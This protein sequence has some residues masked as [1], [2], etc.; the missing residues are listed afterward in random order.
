MSKL[1]VD[2]G[3]LLHGHHIGHDGLHTLPHLSSSMRCT[4]EHCTESSHSLC[5][6]TQ[7]PPSREGEEDVLVFIAL[8]NERPDNSQILFEAGLSLLGQEKQGGSLHFQLVLE[9]LDPVTLLLNSPT[10]KLAT[11]STRPLGTCH[12]Q[13]VGSVRSA[14][15][16]LEELSCGRLGP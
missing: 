12:H 11:C 2:D 5:M 7:L 1:P 6:S 3:L 15:M 9:Y 14:C 10:L 4:S 16:K 13:L 8:L